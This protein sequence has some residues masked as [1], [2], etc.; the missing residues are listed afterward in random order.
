MT[1]TGK[2]NG[3]A[4]KKVFHKAAAKPQPPRQQPCTYSTCPES[5]SSGAQLHEHLIEFHA[6]DETA[7]MIA[8]KKHEVVFASKRTFNDVYSE[9][10]LQLM[11]VWQRAKREGKECLRAAIIEMLYLIQF[12]AATLR[13]GNGGHLAFHRYCFEVDGSDMGGVFYA[14]RD[15]SKVNL[16]DVEG[17]YG[18]IS[19]SGTDVLDG[20]YLAKRV[21]HARSVRYDGLR[22][23]VTDAQAQQLRAQYGGKGRQSE[24]LVELQARSII[25]AYPEVAVAEAIDNDSIEPLLAALSS[26][27]NTEVALP[28]SGLLPEPSLLASHALYPLITPQRSKKARTHSASK[29]QAPS[30]S[31]Q[32]RAS[33]AEV[34]R[35]RGWWRAAAWGSVAI[36]V[37]GVA[38][39]SYKRL[40]K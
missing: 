26:L 27:F 4:K 18:A 23:L 10:A 19:I 21:N 34:Q 6:K 9:S 32:R 22:W 29:A 2:A 25:V 1:S 30:T 17:Y 20:K 16:D 37:V 11:A 7:R 31:T 8:Q 36:L 39:V 33:Q 28:A 5:F 40:A 24:K 3:G 12:N 14:F 15:G 38:F 13:D 35:E